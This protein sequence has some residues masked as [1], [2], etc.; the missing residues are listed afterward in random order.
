M[1]EGPASHYH[2]KLDDISSHDEI[3]NE[4]NITPRSNRSKQS[5]NNNNNNNNN[6][7][8]N[9]SIHGSSHT[10]DQPD[11][12][13]ELDNDFLEFVMANGEDAYKEASDS[14]EEISWS[15]GENEP[16]GGVGELLNSARSNTELK[17]NES[18]TALEQQEICI[19]EMILVSD[20]VTTESKEIMVDDA[21]AL[22]EKMKK[23][24]SI[25]EQFVSIL[26]LLL[27]LQINLMIVLC[28]TEM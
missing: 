12:L 9:S 24:N 5:N 20:R 23:I 2:D 15:D 19:K 26:L 10:C 18:L 3:S 27:P 6:A 25:L 22:D 1:L 7:I 17:L 13:D 14:S 4:G 28:S 21:L 16:N 11:E 8:D